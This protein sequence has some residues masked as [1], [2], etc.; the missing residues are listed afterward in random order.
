MSFRTSAL[1]H[2][3]G[4][5]PGHAPSHAPSHAPGRGRTQRPAGPPVALLAVVLAVVLGLSLSALPPAQAASVPAVPGFSSTIDPY[6]SYEAETT[7]YYPTVWPGTRQLADLLAAT[8]PGRTIGLDRPCSTGPDGHTEGRAIDI[9]FLA[10]NASDFAT[11]T[12]LLSWL[13]ATDSYGNPNAML[14]RFGIMYIIWNGRMWRAY[15][16]S[17]GWSEYL[18]CLSTMTASS[19]DTTCHRNHI[20]ISLSWEGA[21]ATTSYYATL[22]GTT[23]SSSDPCLNG[24]SGC[25]VDRV[26][27]PDRYATSVAVG[28]RAF[29]SSRTVVLASGAA[30]ALA[31]GLVAVPLAYRLK[32]PLLLAQ[33]GGLAPVVAEDILRRGV[34]RAVLVSTAGALG[35]VVV[36]QLH[37]LGVSQVITLGGADPYATSL[38][39]ATAV[40][41]GSAVLASGADSHL[42]DALS[43]GA[44]AAALGMPIVLVPPTGLTPA[45]TRALSGRSPIVLAG[46]PAAIP[47]SVL[48]ALP[49][50]VRLAG[51]DRYGTALAIAG[52][53]AGQVPADPVTFTSGADANL[54][55]ALPSGTLAHTVMLA[56]PTRLGSDVGSWLTSSGAT[57]ATVVGGT[58]AVANTVID[59]LQGLLAPGG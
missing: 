5:A 6:A 49:G 47:D 26:A 44:P 45:L 25:V 41:G 20:H 3:P 42:V 55:D 51:A 13:L 38:A 48:A 54:V 32:A 7:C 50:S 37:T 43:A 33:Q 58:G 39:V 59:Q 21:K 12:G 11:A 16:P 1:R 19:Y 46:G 18:G 53:Y 28:Q 22:A 9:G 17:R 30:G 8:Y 2:A 34:T 36:D 56:A 10:S 31:D 57:G 4:H 52:H 24:G 15:E 35:Q 27:G 29:P 14:R 23:G 40:G